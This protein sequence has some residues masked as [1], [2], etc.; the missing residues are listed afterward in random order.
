LTVDKNGKLRIGGKFAS[1]KQVNRWRS[2]RKRRGLEVGLPLPSRQKQG[3]SSRSES[4]RKAAATRKLN[5]LGIDRPDSIR[6]AGANFQKFDY[7]IGEI[8]PELIEAVLERELI[9]RSSILVNLVIEGKQAGGQDSIAGTSFRIVNKNNITEVAE[10]EAKKL[11]KL[12][13]KYEIQIVDEITVTV[14]IGVARKD[15]K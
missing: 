9:G 5:R 12:A 4:A 13:S 8:E 11:Q 10:T 2:I 1:S 3:K 14:S 15:E 7:K 6:T